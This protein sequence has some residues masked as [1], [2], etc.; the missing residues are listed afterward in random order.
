V[1]DALPGVVHG[2]RHH[3]N[4]AAKREM[5]YNTFQMSRCCSANGTNGEQS[6]GTVWK[7]ILQKRFLNFF[8]GKK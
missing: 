1:E 7:K 6:N 8:P 3:L 4:I 2:A 5:Q